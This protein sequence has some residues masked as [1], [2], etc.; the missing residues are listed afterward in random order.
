[1]SELTFH[2]CKL[3]H[4]DPAGPD[5]ARSPDACTGAGS[6]DKW[7]AQTPGR[8]PSSLARYAYTLERATCHASH[9]IAS[10]YGRFVAGL[11]RPSTSRAS[12]TRPRT[13]F[14]REAPPAPA[15]QPE[16][17]GS[18]RRC[19]RRAATAKRPRP[20]VAPST[21]SAGLP[22]TGHAKLHRSGHPKLHTSKG[23][24][25]RR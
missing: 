8:G 12:A 23:G 22:V 14:F 7:A 15:A 5:P 21:A 2:V 16:P 3:S 24:R 25:Q 13:P 20:S 18:P 11:T 4:S 17:P 6:L 9:T 10:G 19:P 1:M